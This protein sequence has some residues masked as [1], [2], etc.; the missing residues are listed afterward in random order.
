MVKTKKKKGCKHFRNADC[1]C[2]CEPTSNMQ[3]PQGR[4]THPEYRIT[5][6]TQCCQHN[7]A[8]RA[9]LGNT[10]HVGEQR[11]AR[12]TQNNRNNLEEIKEHLIEFIS[13][14]I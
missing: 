9:T 8:Q 11:N 12:V 2:M 14:T 10:V 4:N 6:S 5:G 7:T 1:K 3:M 13:L